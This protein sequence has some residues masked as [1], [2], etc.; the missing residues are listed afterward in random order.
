[1]IHPVTDSR[2]SGASSCAHESKESKSFVSRREL[3]YGG[4]SFGS[5]GL[6]QGSVPENWNGGQFC[7]FGEPDWDSGADRS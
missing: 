6:A 3:L 1:M 4:R 7:G 5:R 2:L